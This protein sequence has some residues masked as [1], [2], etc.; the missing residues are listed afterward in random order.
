VTSTRR[1]FVERL[2]NWYHE[3]G[4]HALPWHEDSRTAFEILVAEV[5]SCGEM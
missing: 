2:L 5:L 4:R 3:N 1:V